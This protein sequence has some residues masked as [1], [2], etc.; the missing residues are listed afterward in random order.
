MS[1]S[2][3]LPPGTLN[4]LAMLLRERRNRGKAHLLRWVIEVGVDEFQESIPTLAT[5]NTGL[6]PDEMEDLVAMSRDILSPSAGK[7]P[8]QHIVSEVLLKRFGRNSNLV[9]YD[10]AP[11]GGP[12]SPQ[13]AKK[14]GRVLDF[15]KIDSKTTE[16]IWGKVESGLRDA[17]LSARRAAILNEPHH[18]ETIKDAIAL[19]YARGFEVYELSEELWKRRLE[20]GREFYLRMPWLTGESFR[21]QHGLEAAG[22]EAHAQGAEELLRRSRQLHDDGVYFRLLVVDMFEQVRQYAR[23]AGVK[24]YVPE[25]GTTFLIGD[26]PVITVDRHRRLRGATSGVPFASSTTVVMPLGRRCAAALSQSNDWQKLPS[27]LVNEINRWQ[28]LR[29]RDHVYYHPEDDFTNFI[30]LVRPTS[31]PAAAST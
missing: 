26:T 18:L 8:E 1:V 23:A 22:P 31:R 24:I 13:R 2:Q 19:H 4:V 21:R 28:I 16:S 20:Y 25:S 30:E 5:L 12:Q 7:M 11:V 14:L 17:L 10:L 29:A 15:V 3:P 27:T 9:P 6:S